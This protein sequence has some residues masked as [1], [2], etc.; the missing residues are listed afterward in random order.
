MT[1]DAVENVC[2]IMSLS[3]KQHVSECHA[4]PWVTERD[5]GKQKRGMR[6][7]QIIVVVVVV[8]GCLVNC[9]CHSFVNECQRH[10]ASC[11]N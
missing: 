11:D 6:Q 5:K 9:M 10:P 7:P 8:V 1:G 2:H 3:F 4:A